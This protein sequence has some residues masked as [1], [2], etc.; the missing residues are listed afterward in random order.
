MYGYRCEYCE[1]TV[2][3]RTVKPEAFKHRDSFVIL[4]K[5]DDNISLSASDDVD[6]PSGQFLGFVLVSVS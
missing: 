2:Q 3:P 4:E 6:V 5:I 1:G